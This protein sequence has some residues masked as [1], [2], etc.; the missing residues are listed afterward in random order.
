MARKR[1]GKATRASNFAKPLEEFLETYLRTDDYE[2][3]KKWLDALKANIQALRRDC[4]DAN[5][6]LLE[7][8][9]KLPSQILEKIVDKALKEPTLP[10]FK[11]DANSASLAFKTQWIRISLY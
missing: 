6:K 7:N 8:L 4:F 2:N 10:I 1:I 5:E 3:C 11:N 9:A